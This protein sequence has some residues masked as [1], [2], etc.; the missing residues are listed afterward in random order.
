M[1]KMVMGSGVLMWKW[2]KMKWVSKE[3]TAGSEHKE[4]KVPKTPHKKEPQDKVKRRVTLDVTFPTPR[5]SASSSSPSSRTKSSSPAS[6]RTYILPR[7]PRTLPTEV[8]L[9]IVDAIYHLPDPDARRLALAAASRVSRSWRTPAQILLFR[10]V[11]LKSQRGYNA[12]LDA[13]YMAPALADA[14]VSLTA[15]FDTNWASAS[16][17]LQPLYFAHAVSECPNLRILD[18]VLQPGVRALDLS[19]NEVGLEYLSLGPA[20]TTLR[21]TS[22]D[23]TSALLAQILTS[24]PSIQH[25]YLSGTALA[26][27]PPPYNLL[28]AP[29]SLQTLRL[30]H[31][32]DPAHEFLAWLLGLTQTAQTLRVLEFGFER[33][34]SPE[35]LALL[36]AAHGQGLEAI[37]LPDVSPAEYVVVRELCPGLK[38]LRVACRFRG[39]GVDK[40]RRRVSWA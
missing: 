23:A 18:V 6:T 21:Y 17:P 29:V 40:K 8:V 3:E 38:E 33:Q 13:L 26:I 30:E 10:E 7:K 1:P 31:T 16:L 32:A 22:H 12:F 37:R 5:R 20:V 19:L 36:V 9:A 15:I 34:P 25:L 28:P 39:C 11:S 2:P 27:P 24:V 35:V 14:A 4:H